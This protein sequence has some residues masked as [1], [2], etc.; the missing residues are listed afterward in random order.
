M[1]ILYNSQKLPGYLSAEE[2]TAI[3]GMVRETNA[4]MEGH[5][6]YG[7]DMTTRLL[8]F[9]RV[10]RSREEIAEFVGVRTQFYVVAKYI[11]PL[12]E[13]GRLQMTLPDKP[14]SKNQRYYTRL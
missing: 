5:F 10:P 4:Y 9:C 14:K 2:E 3:P 1:V 12:L 8:A 7:T 11:K 13:D 6:L